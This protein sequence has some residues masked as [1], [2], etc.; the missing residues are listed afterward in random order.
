M[1]PARSPTTTGD[2][3]H[4]CA[5]ARTVSATSE[6]VRT[7]VTTSTSFITGAG[8]KKCIPITRSGRD[9]AAA[10]CV[11]DNELVFVAKIVSGLHKA[12]SRPKRSFLMSIRS[13]TASMTKSTVAS[14]S[15]LTVQLIESKTSSAAVA[16]MRPRS[17]ARA[18]DAL[19]IACPRSR[20][21]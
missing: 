16:S 8:L 11:T 10:I 9:V 1:N 4:D 12:S 5:S 19:R 17:T 13:G 18:S 20:A 15:K 14:S 2:L 7:V 6:S 21:A 3:P